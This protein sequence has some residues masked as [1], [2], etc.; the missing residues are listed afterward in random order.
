M[1]R[2]KSETRR[3]YSAQFRAAVLAECD[4]AGASV[5]KVAMRHGI[6][7][8]VVHRW[9]QL[10]RQGRIV[11]APAPSLPAP[12]FVPVAL[13]SSPLAAPAPVDARDGDIQIQLRRSGTA[14]TIT[15][16]VGAASQCAQ[17]LRELLA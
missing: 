14:V 1:A 6:N 2:G 17:W 10:V 12:Q 7:A 5:A 3:S 9:R 13:A 4:G 8:N 11:A 16:P 15:W